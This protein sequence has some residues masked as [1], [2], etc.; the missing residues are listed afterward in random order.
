MIIK[1][2]SGAGINLVEKTSIRCYPIPTSDFVIVEN[3]TEIGDIEVYNMMGQKV[4]DLKSNGTNSVTID[5]TS[6]VPGIYLVK[7]EKT[8]VKIVKR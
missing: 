4:V 8:I 7:A 5:L 1:L 6:Q 3:E 2:D